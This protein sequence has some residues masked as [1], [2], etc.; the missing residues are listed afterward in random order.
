MTGAPEK[1]LQSRQWQQ[2]PQ[3]LAGVTINTLF[4]TVGSK[5]SGATMVKTGIAFALALSALSAPAYSQVFKCVNQ[6]G[7]TTFSD[8]P[9]AT[10]DKGSIAHQGQTPEQ[11]LN[12]QRQYEEALANKAA[13]QTRQLGFDY[14]EPSQTARFAPP[15]PTT[16]PNDTGPGKRAT[17][18]TL[19]PDGAG[20][21]QKEAAHQRRLQ[22]R[23][24]QRMA[25]PPSPAPTSINC[26]GAFCYD[27][28]GGTYHSH[29]PGS[30]TMTSPSGGTCVRVGDMVHC[31]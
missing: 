3:S 9:C 24:A 27:N 21:A 4:A 19:M 7:K 18:S 30:V 22:E 20:F 23:R 25:A 10:S 11:A 8:K 2:I 26:S 1:S 29:G 16:L 31:N 17:I 15:R 28:Q 6:Y 12:A 5:Q 13:Q 14:S